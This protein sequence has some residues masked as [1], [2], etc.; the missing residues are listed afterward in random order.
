MTSMH[1]GTWV[2]GCMQQLLHAPNWSVLLMAKRLVAVSLTGNHS[3]QARAAF[4]LRSG[5]AN[6]A[7]ANPVVQGVHVNTGQRMSTLESQT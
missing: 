6:S 4:I 3:C 2:S 1:H 7:A 5:N